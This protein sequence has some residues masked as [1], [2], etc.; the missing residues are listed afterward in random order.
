VNAVVT[1]HA[2]DRGRDR[3][4][5]SHAT[6]E[7]MASRALLEGF[8]RSDASG[9]LRRH[10]DCLV[11]KHGKGHNLRVYGQHVYIFEGVTLITVL[12]LP[13]RYASAAASIA[14][15]KERA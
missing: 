7:R 11:H 8:A 10:L 13:H 1:H 12:H 4:G 9:A 5:W 14:K 15:R 3:L 2:H 6:M